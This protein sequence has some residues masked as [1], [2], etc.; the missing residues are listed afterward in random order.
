[1]SW[2]GQKRAS[3]RA[4][5][6]QRCRG[7]AALAVAGA[8]AAALS[9]SG[10]ASAE[11]LQLYSFGQNRW[12]QLGTSANSGSSSPNP[13]PGAISLPDAAGAPT[14]VAAGAAH[15]LL[16]TSTGQLFAFGS[17][18]RGQLGVAANVGLANPNPTPLLVT[19]PEAG[20]PAESVA[21]GALYSLAV[22]TRGQL[23]A[24]GD[25]EYGQLGVA[26]NVGTAKPNPTPMLVTLPGVAGSATEVAAG[27]SHGLALTSTGQLFAFGENNY[28]QLGNSTNVGLGVAN[29]IPVSVALPTA[30]GRVTQIGAGAEQTFAD[31][32][33]AQVLAFGE[34]NYGELGNTMNVGT[35][36]P[37]SMPTAVGLPPEARAFAVAGGAAAQSTFV[38]TRVPPFAGPN[39]SFRARFV[40]MLGYPATGNIAGAGAALDLEYAIEGAEYLGFAAPLIG[41]DL[42]MPQGFK[43]HPS[44]FPTCAEEGL[45]LKG[46]GS[47]PIRSKAGGGSAVGVVPLGSTRVPEEATIES[48]FTPGGGLFSYLSGHSPLPLEIPLVGTFSPAT[49]GAS[50]PELVAQIPLIEA[51]SGGPDTSLERIHLRFGSAFGSGGKKT[52]YARVPDACPK[53]Y[54][55]I[56]TVLT[57]ASVAGLPQREVVR[58][59]RMPCPRRV[60][61]TGTVAP[62]IA[63]L[64]ETRRIWREGHRPATFSRRH[65]PPIGTTFTFSLSEQAAVSFAFTQQVVGRKVNLKCV[66]RTKRNRRKSACRRTVARGKL[67]FMGHAGNNRVSFQGRISHSNRL[68]LG[69]YTLVITAT[70]AA[71]QHSIPKQLSFTIVK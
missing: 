41:L 53:A 13:T 43:L 70:N 59:F 7:L 16:V 51:V 62:V 69:S 49:S 60:V 25:N 10:T 3:F 20:G 24:F 31:T 64:A 52:Y 42:Y 17:N 12:G 21:A 46:P 35:T 27:S 4:R 5:G 36:E 29:P 58:G 2:H 15:G 37:D 14:Q 30:S 48:F 44:G 40:P 34:N 47:C 65:R 71:G 9:Q 23:F 55:P 39:V 11:T 33:S 66:A 1:V 32:S 8:L 38:T 45:K 54:L 56:K 6:R 19:L 26:A 18:E 22:T 63:G 67:T 50:G 57:F 28:G 61:S 68:G